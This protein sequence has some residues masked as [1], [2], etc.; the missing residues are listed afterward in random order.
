MQRIDESGLSTRPLIEHDADA[1]PTSS[2]SYSAGIRSPWSQVQVPDSTEPRSRTSDLVGARVV[3]AA[4]GATEASAEANYE[5]SKPTTAAAIRVRKRSYRRALKRAART[6]ETSY[7]GRALNIGPVYPVLKPEAARQRPAKEVPRLH[8]LTWNAS[9][10][11]SELFLEIIVWLRSKQEVQIFA[12]QE[13]HW[14]KTLEWQQEGWS[15]FHSA[16]GKGK[17]AGVLLGVRADVA[18]NADI[19]WTEVIPG[20]LMHWRGYIGKQQLDILN[21]Y[22]HALSFRNEEQKQSVMKQR[23]AVWKAVDKTLAALPFRSSVALLGDFNA[24]LSPSWGTIGPGVHL[25][26]SHAHLSAAR[27]SVVDLLSLHRLCALNTWGRKQFTYRHPNGSSQIDFICV[28]QQLA[29]SIAKRS[30]V[31]QAPIAGWRSAGHDVVQCSIPLRWT[32]WFRQ[33]KTLPREYDGPSLNV[34]LS[35]PRPQL[36]DIQNAV[37]AITPPKQPPPQKPALSQ[38]DSAVKRLWQAPRKERPPRTQ[39]LQ[40]FRASRAE[41]EQ[42]RRH[43]ELRKIARQRKRQ[44]LLDI[45]Q[46]VEQAAAQHDTRTQYRFIRMLAPKSFRR[47][48]C[49]RAANGGLMSPSEEADALLQYAVQLFKGTTWIPP[50]LP[51]N[52]NWFRAADWQRAFKKLSN[53][54]AVP[55]SA[56]S[57]EGWKAVAPQVA[58]ALETIAI[59]TVAHEAPTLPQ[60]WA[61]TQLAWLPKPGQATSSPSCLRTIGLLGPDSKAF[62]YIL[63]EHANPFVQKALASVPQFAYRQHA[64]TT[65]ALLRASEHCARVRLTLANQVDDVTARV[66]QTAPKDLVGGLMASIDLSKAFDKLSHEEIMLCLRETNIPEELARMILHVHVRT[67]VTIRH[68]GHTRNLVMGQGL[69][70]GCPIAPMVYAA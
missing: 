42:R 33:H 4:S 64:S 47:R 57:V 23:Q 46:Q 6:G 14:S 18:Q 37:K 60:E 1:E 34:L 25:G 26:S 59:H 48:I 52:P 32:P 56:G 68:K 50:L 9:G 53:H 30:G 7:R 2:S 19:S 41:L 44:Q 54:K 45:L 13:T 28:R 65:D 62:L 22:Q 70:Q 69:R 10:L 5:A 35:Q 51:L 58:S 15:L 24:S 16:S 40:A 12:I 31:I 49:L 43:R 3:V 20:R 36:K 29:D 11:S 67:E 38:V 66:L 55:D 27:Q 21:L 17:Q 63:K 8:M 61:R 39:M